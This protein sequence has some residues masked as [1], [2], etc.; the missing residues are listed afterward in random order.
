MNK[1]KLLKLEQVEDTVVLRALNQSSSVS[2][3][4]LDRDR[5]LGNRPWCVH[6]HV[7]MR[8]RIPRNSA[9]IYTVF[10]VVNVVVMFLAPVSR[11]LVL[12]FNE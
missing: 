11:S 10:S 5:I 9:R 2:G 12:I 6:W 4:V 3:H 7:V 1:F 8:H